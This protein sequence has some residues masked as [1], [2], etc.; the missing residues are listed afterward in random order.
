M[1]AQI[2]CQVDFSLR[3]STV[4]VVRELE[5]GGRVAELYNAP[6]VKLK[7]SPMEINSIASDLQM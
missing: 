7:N 4:G 6:L 2:R 3:G 1:V 5:W